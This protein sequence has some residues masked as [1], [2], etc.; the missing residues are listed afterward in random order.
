MPSE[1]GRS[2]PFE[3]ELFIKRDINAGNLLIVDDV[4][5]DWGGN[6]CEILE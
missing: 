3:T 2:W 4:Q 5:N 1:Y 6:L